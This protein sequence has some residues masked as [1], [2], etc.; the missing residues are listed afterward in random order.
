MRIA[1]EGDWDPAEKKK[2][3]FTKNADKVLEFLDKKGPGKVS[4]FMRE[5]LAAEF[6]ARGRYIEVLNHAIAT[7]RD[8]IIN[9]G[10]QWQPHVRDPVRH[11]GGYMDGY[12][13]GLFYAYSTS[14]KLFQDVIGAAMEAVTPKDE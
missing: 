12:R 10:A 2:R 11:D 6:D 5:S 9:H 1:A 14:C 4:A 13:A 3:G 7:A 8:Q